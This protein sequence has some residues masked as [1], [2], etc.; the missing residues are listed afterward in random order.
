MSSLSLTGRF[1]TWSGASCQ[2]QEGFGH[3]MALPC[4]ANSIY[5]FINKIQKHGFF[6]IF[7]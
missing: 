6:S 4:H 5:K 3:G 2:W 1:Q 7:V